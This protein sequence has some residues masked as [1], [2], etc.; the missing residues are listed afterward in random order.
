MKIKLATAKD[1]EEVSAIIKRHAQQ[2]YMG[3]ATFDERYVKS[4][5][6]RNNFF[7]VADFIN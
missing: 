3:Y 6:K 4:K 7:F 1:A 2:D 5:M